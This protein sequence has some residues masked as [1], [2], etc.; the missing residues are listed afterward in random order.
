MSPHSFTLLVFIISG[1]LVRDAKSADSKD[2]AKVTDACTAWTNLRQSV[3]SM[4]TV[5]KFLCD[6]DADC[7]GINC[8]CRFTLPWKSKPIKCE[9]EAHLQH[10]CQKPVRLFVNVSVPVMDINWTHTFLESEKIP[11]TVRGLGEPQ[12]QVN[13]QMLKDD[14]L[15]LGVSLIK[16]SSG[17]YG[18]LV[19]DL[20]HLVGNQTIALPPCGGTSRPTVHRLLTMDNNKRNLIAQVAV[21]QENE[22]KVVNGMVT[23]DGQPCDFTVLGGCGPSETCEQ[24]VFGRSQGACKCRPHYHRD[25]HGSCTADPTVPSSTADPSA[26]PNKKDVDDG[27][28]G[29]LEAV[30]VGVA[31]FAVTILLTL[32][33]VSGYKYRWIPRIRARFQR[34]RTY[35]EM[36]IDGDDFQSNNS[37]T[38]AIA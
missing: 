20:A 35:E 5:D 3:Q 4:G 17:S 37:T 8:T 23:S 14:H 19:P 18:D 29:S 22:S 2:P 32:L 12:I 30:E 38:N 24:I 9:F 6:V 16:G 13:M 21:D 34:A 11:L 15:I 10:E 7:M 25:V 28:G 36:V 1:A 33:F 27:K 26:A 31:V